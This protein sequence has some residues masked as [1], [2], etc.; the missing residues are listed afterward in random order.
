MAKSLR[1]STILLL[2]SF[3]VGGFVAPVLHEMEHVAEWRQSRA[4]HASSV[5]H[6]HSASD[7]HDT[8][9]LPPCPDPLR[10]DLTCVLCHVIKVNDVRA[11]ASAVCRRTSSRVNE[12]S[13]SSIASVA[14]GHYLVRGPPEQAA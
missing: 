2:A 7:D 5:H 11:A 1:H 4:E 10:I 12:D 14:H 9:A 8:E 13:S 3:V 6:H